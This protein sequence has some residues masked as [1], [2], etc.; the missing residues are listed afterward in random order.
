MTDQPKAHK[1]FTD[2][3]RTIDTTKLREALA[4]Y[5]RHCDERFRAE[6]DRLRATTKQSFDEFRERLME[7]AR[8][9]L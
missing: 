5:D 6:L 4:G 9:E 2:D 3:D 8:R 1:L 7:L